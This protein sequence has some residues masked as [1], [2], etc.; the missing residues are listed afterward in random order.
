MARSV[1]G[2]R[3]SS[4]DGAAFVEWRVT[5]PRADGRLRSEHDRARPAEGPE[6][7]GQ[8]RSRRRARDPR[9]AR[10]PDRR[11]RGRA[12]RRHVRPRGRAQRRV[13]RAFEAV[14]LRD[15]GDRYGGKGV[16]QGGRRGAGHHRPG[17]GRLRGQRAA[18][19]RPGAASTS[20]ARRTRPGSAPTRS[21]ASRS[22][23][24][25]PPRAAP[26]CRCSATSAAQAPTCCRCR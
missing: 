1:T 14:E 15:G 4:L 25:R 17:A 12:R 13:H 20:T 11:G 10:Q 9:L 6:T 2:P 16:Q 24:R 18:A 26:N 3:A 21:S 5:A 23:S 22:R 19:D 8:H 7:R